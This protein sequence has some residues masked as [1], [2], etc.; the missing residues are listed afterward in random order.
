MKLSKLYIN[1]RAKIFIV[2]LILNILL[3]SFNLLGGLKKSFPEIN[4]LHKN[5]LTFADLEIFFKKTAEKKGALYA[6]DLLTDAPLPKNTD[7]H[8]LAHAVGNILYK[9]KGLEGIKFCTNDFRNACS[10][11]IVIGVFTERGTDAIDDI[12]KVC[13]SAPGGSGAYG[14]CFHGLGHG[15]LAY[16]G[17]DFSNAISLCRH[18]GTKEYGYIESAECVGGMVMELVAGVHDEFAWEK[19]KATNFKEDNPLYPCDQGFIPSNA[20][21][22]CFIYLTP[23]LWEAVGATPVNITD[24]QLKMAFSFCDQL[25]GDI[26]EFKEACFGGFGKEFVTMVQSEDI[27][28]VTMA[29][30]KQRLQIYRWCLLAIKPNGISAC[31]REAVNSFYW[32]GENA[33]D[34]AISFCGD[35]DD[36]LFQES[37]FDHLIGAFGFYNAGQKKQLK[38]LCEQLPD[39]YRERCYAQNP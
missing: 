29:N 8:L 14:M 12:A 1:N 21:H 16:A 2:L 27:R 22:L 35:V 20:R 19:A 31:L 26:E 7:V 4:Y 36:L 5:E 32:G 25:T 28:K 30:Q 9:Q 13:R 38:F 17:Y 23:H 15:V 6:F 11:A 39:S 24:E 33:P 18:V 3:F 10:H 37:C 34:T